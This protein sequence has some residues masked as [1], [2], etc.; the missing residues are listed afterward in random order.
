MGVVYIALV[1]LSNNAQFESRA[2]GITRRREYELRA[3]ASRYSSSASFFYPVSLLCAIYCLNMLLRRVSDH[4]SHSY[5][6]TA[7]DLDVGRRSTVARRVF[8]W[9]DCVGQYRLYYWVRTLNVISVLLCSLH[10]VSR[11]VFV[12][13]LSNVAGLFDQ[14]AA[15]TDAAG[16]ETE[17]S[18]LISKGIEVNDYDRKHARAVSHAF[19]AAVLIPMTIAFVMFF[20]ASIVMFRRVER[21]LDTLIQEMSLRSD[22]GTAFLPFEF[23][24]PAADGSETQTELPIVEARLF[25]REI[26]SSAAVQRRKFKLCLFLV[27]IALL[28]LTS[29]TMFIIVVESQA[30]HNPDCLD[31]CGS[32]QL[33]W[34]V[35]RTWDDNLPEIGSLTVSLCLSIP[36]LFSLWLMTTPE[37]RALLMNPGKFLTDEIRVHPVET[38]SEAKL[39]FERIR[40]GINMQ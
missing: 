4:A 9:R 40:L 21:R 20:P 36:L 16:G 10:A 31:P 13:I 26:K 1:M 25:L 33:L 37:D 17:A 38:E 8:D 22:H 19:E 30:T 5:Y 11:F 3:S 32:C 2:I 34:Y 23:S 35:I 39:R 12:G 27:M 29:H 6:N 24:P 15:A 28:A 18:R 7:R 14:A